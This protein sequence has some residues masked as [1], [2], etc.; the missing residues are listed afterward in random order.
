MTAT[1]ARFG[2]GPVLLCAV[3][4][5]GLLLD[6]V[7]IRPEQAALRRLSDRKAEL[8]TLR[9]TAESVARGAARGAATNGA[10]GPAVEAE[11]G[12]SVRS[13]DEQLRFLGDSA[14]RA[15][16][17]QRKLQMTARTVRGPVEEASFEMEVYGSFADVLTFLKALELSR[18]L[19]IVSGVH[20]MAP[21]M[22]SDVTLRIHAAMITPAVAAAG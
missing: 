3:M 20:L 14:R 2:W 8:L 5:V 12:G 11:L 17:R 9:S 22:S 18:P 10:G 13:P 1:R 19:I 6:R 15:G 7:W 21:A 4:A 16:V